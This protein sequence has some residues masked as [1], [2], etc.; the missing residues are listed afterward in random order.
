MP[1]RPDTTTAH[2][3]PPFTDRAACT[4]TIRIDPEDFFPNSGTPARA[5]AYCRTRC[6]VRDECLTWALATDQRHGVWGGTTANQRA[7]LRRG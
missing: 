2:A 4:D 3:R 5:L 6:T 7:A 1:S